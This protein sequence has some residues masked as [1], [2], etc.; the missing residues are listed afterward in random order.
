MLELWTLILLHRDLVGWD[1]LYKVLVHPQNK[2]FDLWKTFNCQIMQMIT[3][4]VN[5]YCFHS[6]T[7]SFKV[8]LCSTMWSLQW[9][10]A[11]RI[12]KRADYYYCFILMT[13]SGCYVLLNCCLM[14]CLSKWILPFLSFKTRITGMHGCHT[15]VPKYIMSKAIAVYWVEGVLIYKYIYIERK[16]KSAQEFCSLANEW[17][18]ILYCR[19]LGSKEAKGF[20]RHGHSQMMQTGTVTLGMTKR[21]VCALVSVCVGGGL[22]AVSNGSCL[23]GPWEI[24][25]K[26][27]IR[28]NVNND[29]SSHC[30]AQDKSIKDPSRPV[31]TILC[32]QHEQ[33]MSVREREKWGNKRGWIQ[34]TKQFS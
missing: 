4:I 25:L 8:H 6:C 31:I 30:A 19:E 34:N 9:S 5:Q 11:P 23:T 14:S 27:S 18:E 22:T 1:W 29:P 26:R 32:Q 28:Y 21:C 7:V 3:G 10:C 12:T 17:I 20:A 24:E 2:G 33:K 13:L 15:S 16:F